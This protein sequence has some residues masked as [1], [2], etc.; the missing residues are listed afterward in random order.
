MGGLLHAVLYQP[1]YNLLIGLYDIIP[2]HDMGLAIIA[3]TIL[4]KLVFWPL[5][6]S[7]LLS[8]KALQELQ[9]K[10]DAL[11]AAHGADK[12]A[13]GKA[14]IALYASEKVNPLSSCLP[15]LVQLPVLFALYAV[16]QSGLTTEGFSNLYSFVPN[17]GGINETF[18]GIL[19]LTKKNV[20]L[21]LVTGL[22]TFAQMRMLT[23]TRVKKPVPEGAKDED[24]LAAMN[25]SMQYTMPVMTAVIGAGLPAGLL[26][27]WITNTLVSIGQQMVAFRKKKPAAV[28]VI[29]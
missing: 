14:V 21:A 29:G 4:V 20:P 19:D 25:K 8:Q 23:A 1:L 16:L 26:L 13:F 11:K 6:H 10:I 18:L 17:P 7:S 2:G 15:V 28:E 22:A 27:Y 3:L 9:P 5:N 12:D 24:M